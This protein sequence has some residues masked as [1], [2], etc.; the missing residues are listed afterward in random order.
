MKLLLDTNI[1]I[2]FLKGKNN[3]CDISS[4]L[5]EHDCFTSIIV[6]LELL[7]YQNITSDEETAIIELLKFIPII[8]INPSIESETI[9]ISRSSKLKLPDAIIGATAIVYDAEIVTSDDHLIE[10]Q[11]DKLKIWNNNA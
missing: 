9:L 11:Y 5:L 3:A 6:K 10:C 8:Q 2:D 4:L 1:I 7:K